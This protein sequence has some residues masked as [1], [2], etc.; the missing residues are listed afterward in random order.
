MSPT[1]PEAIEQFNTQEF[2]ACHDTLEALWMEAIEPDRTFYQGLLQI[3]VGLYHFSTGNQRGAMILLGE[4]MGR[5]QSYRPDY[6]GVALDP[7]LAEAKTWLTHL[8][9]QAPDP[10]PPW[11]QVRSIA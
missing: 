2:Y 3:A 1:F 5:L 11:P 7:L 4:G 6:G 10:L 8:Q 9:T